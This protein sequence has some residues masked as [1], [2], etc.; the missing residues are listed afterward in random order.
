VPVNKNSPDTSYGT[1][2]FASINSQNSTIFQFDIPQSYSGNECSVVF[3]WPEQSQLETSSYTTSGSGGL[4]FSELN[5]QTTTSTT[6]QSAGTGSEVGSVSNAAAGNSY[7]IA[8]GS[9]AAGQSVS[10]EVSATGSLSLSFFE[11]WNPSPIGVF[12][13][14]C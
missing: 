4:T 6:Y 13:T 1:Q 11:D 8:S 2:Y 3:L 14:T 9:C 12:I 5:S 10:Y 7:V